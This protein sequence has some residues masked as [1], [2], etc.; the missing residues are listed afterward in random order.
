M[1]FKQ[2]ATLFS[3]VQ[4]KK[5]MAQRPLDLLANKYGKATY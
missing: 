1:N 5:C 3:P 2:T 4:E